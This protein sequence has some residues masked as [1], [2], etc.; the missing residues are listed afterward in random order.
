MGFSE[1]PSTLLNK[2]TGQTPASTTVTDAST[3]IVAAN[4]SRSSVFVTNFGKNDVWIACDVPALV[5]NGICL[6]ANGGSMLVD[7]TAFTSGPINGICNTGK[8]SLMIFQ[9]LNL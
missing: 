1:V 5:D 4:A 7:S 2:G 8:T 6:A 3:E 9:E